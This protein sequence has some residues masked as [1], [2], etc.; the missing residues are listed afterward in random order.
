MKLCTVLENTTAREDL[1]PEHGLSLYVET[2][3]RKILFDTGQSGL[4]WDNAARMGLDLAQVDTAV[5]SHGH[6]DHGG[7]LVRFL[8]GNARARVYVS[9]LA[10]GSYYHGPEKYIGLPPVLRDDPRLT[11]VDRTLSLGDGLTLYPDIPLRD[12]VNS[13]G[14]QKQQDGR[15]VPDDFRHEQYLLLEEGGK[16][17][18]FSGCSHRGILNIA[19]HFRPDVLIGGFHFMKLD[20]QTREGRTAL[21]QA[22][23]SLLALPCVYYTCHCTGIPQYEFLKT[24]LGDRLHYLATGSRLTL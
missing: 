7:G 24:I 2:G 6:Y 15:L 4:Y 22:A 9:S 10:F 3:S 23:E 16:R 17:I 8:R 12:P 21:T 11:A 5:L 13:W 14:L 1:I 19:R 18:L 20:P